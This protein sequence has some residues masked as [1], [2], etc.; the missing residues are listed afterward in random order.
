[1]DQAFR[2]CPGATG[3]C[4]WSWL[5][6]RRPLDSVA[7]VDL[8]RQKASTNEHQKDRPCE[9][10]KYPIYFQRIA[11]TPTPNPFHSLSQLSSTISSLSCRNAGHANVIHLPLPH[12]AFFCLCIAAR[13][14]CPPA[15]PRK[16]V[17]ARTYRPGLRYLSPSLQRSFGLYHTPSYLSR[18]ANERWR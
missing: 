3:R 4:D 6:R 7:S 16:P 1:M 10:E 14:L 9:N 12:L 13:A 2:V 8:S 11:V 15:P 18:Q 17:I 5:G